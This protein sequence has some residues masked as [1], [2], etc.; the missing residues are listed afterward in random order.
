MARLT[1]SDYD[2]LERAIARGERLAVLRRGTEFVLVP[3]RLFVEG[4][5]EAIEAVHPTT[6]ERMVLVLD[7]IDRFDVVR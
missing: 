3:T 2:A 6:G 5:R 1:T 4:G 7:D